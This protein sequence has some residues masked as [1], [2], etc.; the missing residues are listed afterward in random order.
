M[1]TKELFV[2][3]LTAIDKYGKTENKIYNASNGAID[4]LNIEELQDIINIL[5]NVLEYCTKCEINDYIGSDINYFMGEVEFGKNADKYFTTMPD[6][7]E[8]HWHTVED[9]WNY[10]VMQHPEIEDKDD[11]K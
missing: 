2:K 1:I 6:G 8:Y 11:E 3:A 9:L 4:L 10:L 7:T 5:V